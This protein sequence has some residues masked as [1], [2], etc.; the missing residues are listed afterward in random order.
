M[1]L[2]RALII[3]AGVTALLGVA[4]ILLPQSAVDKIAA[5]LEIRHRGAEHEKIALIYLTDEFTDGAFRIRGIVRNIAET[6]MERID[7]AVRLY[8]N[9]RA[10]LETVVVRLDKEILAPDDFARLE[11]TVPGHTEGFAGYAVEFKLR[12]GGILPYKDMRSQI[13]Q[14]SN[15]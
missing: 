8:S 7:A 1:D 13:S 14:N 6:P 9:G 3:I 10:L 11:M 5:R 15:P 2:C 12:D 4:L